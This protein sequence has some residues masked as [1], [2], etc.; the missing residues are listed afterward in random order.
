MVLEK[1][2]KIIEQI[3]ESYSSDEIQAIKKEY[4][5][6]SGEIFDDDKSYES[7]MASFLE[8]FALD[9]LIPET[10]E[11]AMEKYIHANIDNIPSEEID[12]YYKFTETI[13]AIFIVKKIKAETI[14]VLNLFDDKKYTVTE[15]KGSVIFQKNDIFEGRLIAVDD[16]YY[17][18]GAFCFHPQNA[19][20]FIEAK[21][22][23][24]KQKQKKILNDL[25]KLEK[26]VKS[27]VI[28]FNS[29]SSE[30]SKYT[31]KIED[32]DSESKQNKFTEK[33]EISEKVLS[34][35]IEE[36]LK[37]DSQIAELETF[38]IKIEG[39]EKRLK[40]IH[41]LSYLN[42]MWERSRQIDAKDIYKN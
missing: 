13:H 7:R 39:R 40:L 38:K 19:Y 35:V 14:K 29:I 34:T 12:L 23:E 5:K 25:E 17:F 30:I 33:I 21:A 20:K 2:N 10:N 18:T 3:A 36:R 31:K 6:S 26:I 32:T 28:N 27:I 4:Q 1:L 9:R 24:I 37:I 22:R 42:L 8:W 16:K 11:T 15:N 41:R